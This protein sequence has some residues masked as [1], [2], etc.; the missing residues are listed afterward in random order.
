MNN[1]SL[2]GY[3]QEIELKQSSGGK[4]WVVGTIRVRNRMKNTEGKYD[5]SFFD[6]KVFGQRVDTFVKYQ[7][8]GKPL[9]ITGDLV[10]ERW[11]NQEGQNRSKVVIH[12]QDFDLPPF[13]D[14]TPKQSAPK[15][16]S[17]HDAFSNGGKI[18]LDD[19]DLPF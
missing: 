9:A 4:Q 3:A 11:T 2:T 15:M 17:D 10:Q 8:K 18:G 12:V 7:E 1:I 5:S 19:D 14:N 13:D 16:A 6:F